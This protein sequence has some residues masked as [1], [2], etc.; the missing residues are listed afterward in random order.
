VSRVGAGVGAGPTA[1]SDTLVCAPHNTTYVS[2]IADGLPEELHHSHQQRYDRQRR[3]QEAQGLLNALK[4]VGAKDP[5][6]LDTNN[7]QANW[8]DEYARFLSKNDINSTFAEKQ[9][10]KTFTIAVYDKNEENNGK[11]PTPSQ[12][13]ACAQPGAAG[14]RADSSQA[15]T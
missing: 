15:P 2:P 12:I 1:K 3:E 7:E 6:T 9:T 14:R 10:I 5:I 13:A 11:G 4:G 8:S